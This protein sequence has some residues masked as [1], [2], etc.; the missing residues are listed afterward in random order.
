MGLHRGC[1]CC[2]GGHMTPSEARACKSA[3]LTLLLEACATE[4]QARQIMGE[5][6]HD[7]TAVCQ[8][9]AEK[10]LH[11]QHPDTFTHEQTHAERLQSAARAT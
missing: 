4:Q 5:A 7:F 2:L 1:G 11:E 6:M 8:W 3:I 9:G 10:I